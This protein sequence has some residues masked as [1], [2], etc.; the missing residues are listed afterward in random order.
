MERR[1]ILPASRARVL[2]LAHNVV[3]EDPQGPASMLMGRIKLTVS[4]ISCRSTGCRRQR[5]LSNDIQQC[6]YSYRNAEAPCIL[7][8]RPVHRLIIQVGRCCQ[9][10]K[11]PNVRVVEIR[12]AGVLACHYG[13]CNCVPYPRSDTAA[14]LSEV[15]GILVKEC[16]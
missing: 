4:A 11:T 6:C 9:R 7:C 15:T 2:A 1:A 8:G 13:S 12:A 16:R 10:R 5:K 14:P 3:D